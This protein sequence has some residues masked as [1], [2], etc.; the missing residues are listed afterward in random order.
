MTAIEY[1]N[2]EWSTITAAPICIL[3]I[4]LS[5]FLFGFRCAH[6][7]YAKTANLANQRR[8]LSEDQC[9]QLAAK[10]HDL[11]NGATSSA[12]VE[13]LRRKIENLPRVFTGPKEPTGSRDGDIWIQTEQ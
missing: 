5:A 7:W 12:T 2:K 3:T 13:E 10:L 9:K 8:E 11:H 4:A 6:F 1:I